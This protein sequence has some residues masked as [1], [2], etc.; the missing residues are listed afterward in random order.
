MIEDKEVYP[1]DKVIRKKI[2]SLIDEYR[3]KYVKGETMKDQDPS[4]IRDI[5]KTLESKANTIDKYFNRPQL[6]KQDPSDIELNTLLHLLDNLSDHNNP[7]YPTEISRCVNIL[8]I[9]FPFTL[10]QG[11]INNLMKVY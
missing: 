4:S 9:Q 10:S 5:R 3:K 7:R 2:I 6:Y 11:H 1:I 8:F